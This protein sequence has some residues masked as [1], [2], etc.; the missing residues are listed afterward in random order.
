MAIIQ[1]GL[2]RFTE[3][4]KWQMRD[5]RVLYVEDDP[6]LR[7]LMATLLGKGRGLE[8]TGV[9][10]NATEALE[11]AQTINFD[12]ALLDLALGKDSTTGLELAF[13][14]RRTFP[15]L[16]VVIYSQH[17]TGSLMSR[18]PKE[19]LA[20]WSIVQKS[21]NVDFA[22]LADVLRSTARGLSI[23]DP[24][25]RENDDRPESVTATLAPRQR[26]M[27][28]YLAAGADANSIA[29]SM[30]LSPITVRQELSKIYKLL[31]PTPA[32]GTDL[33]TSAVLRYLR[34]TRS[35]AWSNPD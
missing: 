28:G 22:Y 25:I 32:E 4:K 35:Y 11:L 26:E 13:A 17:A 1:G 24:Y 27:M 34:E 6:L 31:V 19:S 18:I 7:S 30:T 5:T 9:A 21:A 14:L 29:A 33:R 20:S 2:G 23:V 10:G 12:V 16:G 3:R 8:I 15:N